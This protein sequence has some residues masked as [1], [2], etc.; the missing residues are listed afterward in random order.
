MKPI[1]FFLGIM[2]PMA[3]YC[4]YNQ[5]RTYPDLTDLSSI[6]DLS[7]F[8]HPSEKLGTWQKAWVFFKDPNTP[9]RYKAAAFDDNSDFVQGDKETISKNEKNRM[10]AD[11]IKSGYVMLDKKLYAE[12]YGCQDFID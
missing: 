3:I 10:I 4:L 6:N 11:V 2:T 5:F 9:N 7:I 1:Y 8:Q 12:R